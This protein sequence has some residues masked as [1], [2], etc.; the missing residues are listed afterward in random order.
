M[1]NESGHLVTSGDHRPLGLILVQ[2]GRKDG[3]REGGIAGILCV[4]EC[5]CVCVCV[6]ACVHTSTCAPL[7]MALQFPETHNCNCANNTVAYVFIR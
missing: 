6:C 5:V 2:R 1:I 4:H 7:Y 3:W